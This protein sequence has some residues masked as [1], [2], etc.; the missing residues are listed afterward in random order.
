MVVVMVEMAL[1]SPPVGMGCFVLKGVNPSLS[2]AS[3]YRGA[4]LFALPILVLLAL[5]LAI[6]DIA[7]WLPRLMR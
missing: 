2:M 1:I 7:L 5:L 3:I 4:L 6:P